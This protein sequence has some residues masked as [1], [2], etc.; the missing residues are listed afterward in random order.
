MSLGSKQPDTKSSGDPCAACG[1]TDYILLQEGP[2]IARRCR[3]CGRWSRW[4]PRTPENLAACEKPAA[5]KTPPLFAV[6]DRSQIQDD[7]TAKPAAAICDHR[8]ELE[9]LI[10][11]LRGIESHLS[12]VTRALMGQPTR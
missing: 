11:H 1:Q 6:P 5:A 7:E 12:I 3:N 2:H 10:H 8:A 4:V 9:R